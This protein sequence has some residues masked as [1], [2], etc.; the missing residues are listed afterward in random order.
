MK[1]LTNWIGMRLTLIPADEFLTGSD[2]SDPAAYDNEFLH[3]AAGKK[4]KHRVRIT[5]PF[6][7]GVTEVTRGQFRRFV[8]EAGYQTEAQKDG[9]GGWGWNDATKQLE[10]NPKF[11]WRNP[12]FEQ[13]DDHPVVNVSWND[14][15][16]FIDWLSRKEGRST[17][18]PPRRTG[19]SG[20]GAG[21]ASRGTRSAFRVRCTPEDRRFYL[22][23]R[24]ARVQSER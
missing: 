24:V 10:Q 15:Q 2:E 4:Q 5:R 22:G 17:S 13:T 19:C 21:S 14:A 16:A 18:C 7:L 23:F 9:K 3:K 8:E 1:A 20:A 11:T 6:Y 12:G